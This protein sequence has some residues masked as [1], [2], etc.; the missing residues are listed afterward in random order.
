MSRRTARP[1]PS[2]L[3]LPTLRQ[4]EAAFSAEGAPLP[5]LVGTEPPDN[6][7]AE[8]PAGGLDA[9]A[10]KLPAEP[11]A[12]RRITLSQRAASRRRARKQR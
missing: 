8:P 1:P 6:P 5:G 2:P 11:A 9:T 3:P 4:Q 10:A 7:A 12:K